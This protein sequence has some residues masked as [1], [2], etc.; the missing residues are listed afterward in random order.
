MPEQEQN[1][2]RK[3]KAQIWL[4]SCL[5]Q[6]A[7]DTTFHIHTH[8][9]TEFSHFLFLLQCLCCCLPSFSLSTEVTLYNT[10]TNQIYTLISQVKRLEL[11]S[12]KKLLWW[13]YVSTEANWAGIFTHHTHCTC[14]LFAHVLQRFFYTSGNKHYRSKIWD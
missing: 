14:E 9:L 2:S 12:L 10:S 1:I 8:S 13:P 6:G 11:Y 5:S 3:D 4:L 7:G